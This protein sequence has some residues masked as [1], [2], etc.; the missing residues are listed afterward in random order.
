M[1]THSSILPCIHSIRKTRDRAGLEARHPSEQISTSSETLLNQAW[2]RSLILIRHY[3]PHM[4]IGTGS[5]HCAPMLRFGCEKSASLFRQ[6]TPIVCQGGPCFSFEH[7]RCELDR[8]EYR[9]HVSLCCW[10]VATH[11]TRRYVRAQERAQPL[12]LRWEMSHWTNRSMFS[13]TSSYDMWQFREGLSNKSVSVNCFDRRHLQTVHERSY[14][15]KRY[16]E[17]L[18]YDISNSLFL[19][20]WKCCSGRSVLPP[21]RTSSSSQRVCDQR[22]SFTSW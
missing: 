12:T 13:K 4:T 2:W 3:C 15:S 17:Q 7:K 11:A 6:T 21:I 1:K 9:W 10:L 20:E 14:Q 5:V 22:W 8:V 19:C 18:F 16:L